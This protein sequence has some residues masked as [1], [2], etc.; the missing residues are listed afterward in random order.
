[1]VAS[2]LAA[3]EKIHER[4]QRHIAAASGLNG[5]VFEVL[6]T[7]DAAEL[8]L[9]PSQISERTRKSSATMTSTL[10]I[11]ERTGFARRTPNPSDRRSLLIEITDSGRKVVE[12]TL[13][14][15]RNSENEALAG[16]SEDE[17]ATARDALGRLI[18]RLDELNSTPIDLTIGRL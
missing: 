2:L 11:L 18:A 7:L 8:P 1:V 17:L 5:P 12:E 15:I 16:W 13:P 4:T 10:D 6:T 9:T 14:R 3:A